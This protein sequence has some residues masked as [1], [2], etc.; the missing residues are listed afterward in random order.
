MSTA[1]GREQA[2]RGSL[3]T[4]TH[5]F[6]PK[7]FGVVFHK[8]FIFFCLVA[9]PVR[10]AQVLLIVVAEDKSYASLAKQSSVVEE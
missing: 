2:S 7:P 5:S 10:A 6:Q 1:S 3:D 8:P 4:P 9:A